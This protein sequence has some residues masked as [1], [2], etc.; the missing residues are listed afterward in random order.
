LKL[1]VLLS[2]HTFIV[3]AVEST[4]IQLTI[5]C[6]LVGVA[7]GV[8]VV[9]NDGVEAVIAELDV[10]ANGEVAVGETVV[11]EASVREVGVD[12][13]EIDGTAVVVNEANV[14]EVGVGKVALDSVAVD[15][16]ALD[17]TA[18]VV[19]E[20]T[21]GEAAVNEAASAGLLFRLIFEV[22]PPISLITSEISIEPLAL[23]ITNV[24]TSFVSH[25]L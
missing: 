1:N 10:T 2:L 6:E 3:V 11:S 13:V 8:T 21:G 25:R 23:S 15:S 9:V 19:E 4:F 5:V 14:S 7:V 17:G 20:T 18:V 24:I 12:V 22:Q 16:V